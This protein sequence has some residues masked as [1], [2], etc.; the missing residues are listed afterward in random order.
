M[1]S[2]IHND[3]SLTCQHQLIMI[4]ENDYSFISIES[5]ADTQKVT[6]NSLDDGL[7]FSQYA[8]GGHQQ[9]FGGLAVVPLTTLQR[10]LASSPLSE[11]EV[12]KLRSIMR[13]SIEYH[14][15]LVVHSQNL[16][17][18]HPVKQF[19]ELASECFRVLHDIVVAISVDNIDTSIVTDLFDEFQQTHKQLVDLEEAAKEQVECTTLR[20]SISAVRGEMEDFAALMNDSILPNL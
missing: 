8:L 2:Q 5:S 6:L 9:Q 10:K 1:L 14:N 17:T 12:M 3:A 13:F 16:A 18:F 11:L 7:C 19:T 20:Q 15:P 4:D